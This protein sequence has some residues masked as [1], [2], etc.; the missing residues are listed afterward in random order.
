MATDPTAIGATNWRSELPT[1]AGRLVVLRGI[2]PQD[3]GPLVDLLSLCDATRFGSTSRS[4]KS[5]CRSS[6]SGRC[7]IA[8]PDSRSP[9]S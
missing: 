5:A 7:A 8:Q 3:L 9:M 2:G 4:A 6:S 1:L